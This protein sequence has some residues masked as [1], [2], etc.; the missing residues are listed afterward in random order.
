MDERVH[1]VHQLAAALGEDRARPESPQRVWGVLL[2]KVQVLRAAMER[3]HAAWLR[4][5]L[6]HAE[7]LNAAIDVLDAN[8]CGHDTHFNG[9]TMCMLHR[10]IS[11]SR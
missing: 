3:E 6:D 7:L 10:A 11:N 5:Q 8:D 4:G 1:M 9:C 2:E